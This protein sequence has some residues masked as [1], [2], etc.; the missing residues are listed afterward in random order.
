MRHTVIKDF[1]RPTVMLLM[2]T[3]SYITTLGAFALQ[4]GPQS[5][6][7]TLPIADTLCHPPCKLRVFHSFDWLL[8]LVV[9]A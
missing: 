2:L 6:H 9:V 8:K 4:M 7:T 5:M 3:I 1:Y